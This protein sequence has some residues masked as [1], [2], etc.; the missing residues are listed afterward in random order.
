MLVIGARGARSVL[1]AEAYGRHGWA[2]RAPNVLRTAAAPND[3]YG[4]LLIDPEWIESTVQIAGIR[5]SAAGGPIE[6]CG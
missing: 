2:V 3:H 1:V 5:A 4:A 6:L